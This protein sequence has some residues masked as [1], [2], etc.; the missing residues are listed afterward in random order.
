MIITL[1]LAGYVATKL[2]EDKGRAQEVKARE[3]ECRLATADED[4]DGMLG[5]EAWVAVPTVSMR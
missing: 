1:M 4:P 3:Q 2:K 5:A